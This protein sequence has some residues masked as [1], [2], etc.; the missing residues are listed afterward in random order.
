[1]NSFEKLLAFWYTCG[2]LVLILELTKWGTFW[3]QFER[4]ANQSG[5]QKVG[6]VVNAIIGT[7]VMTTLWPFRV[8]HFTKV[9]IEW[10]TTKTK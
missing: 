10:V 6:N 8:Y 3:Q 1:M 4:V 7:V 9:F 5:A 2:G